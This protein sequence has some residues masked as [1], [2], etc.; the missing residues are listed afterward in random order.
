MRPTLRDLVNRLRRLERKQAERQ[1]TVRVLVDWDAAE[2][3]D[4]GGPDLRI[5]RDGP[6]LRYRLRLR[7]PD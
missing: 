6:N 3:P 5:E 1:R 4:D 7:W 2:R